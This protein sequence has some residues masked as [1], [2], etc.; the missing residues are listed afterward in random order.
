MTVDPLFKACKPNPEPI[1]AR[2]IERVLR[3]MVID[4]ETGCHIS[5]YSIG[6][7]GYAQIGWHAVSGIRTATTAHRAV[8]AG[9]HG[10]IPA[11]MTVDHTC[12][13]RH[14]VNIEHLRLLTNFENARRTSGRDWPLGFCLHG[15][16]DTDMHYPANGS[17][18]YCR[19]CRNAK[20]RLDRARKRIAA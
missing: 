17:K 5:L 1:P 13:N 10:P 16:P 6:S 3:H 11:G 8:W 18:A 9:V 14:C 7:H 4:T 2:V 20:Q 15:H 19:E 12:K